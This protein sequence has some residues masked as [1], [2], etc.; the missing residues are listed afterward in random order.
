MVDISKDKIYSKQ[1]FKALRSEMPNV[2][3][4]IRKAKSGINANPQRIMNL[5][6]HENKK[7]IEAISIPTNIIRFGCMLSLTPIIFEIK[8]ISRGEIIKR[9][10]PVIIRDNNNSF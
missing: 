6:S 1:I 3:K 5:G 9:E 2:P 4:I 7:T 8:F 10:N